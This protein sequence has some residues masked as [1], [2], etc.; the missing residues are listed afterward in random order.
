MT[1]ITLVIPTL[2]ECEALPRLIRCLATLD[3]Q[4]DEIIL[5]DGGSADDTAKL[6]DYAGFKV[7]HQSPKGR[8]RQ[9]NKGVEAA[10]HDVVCVLHADTILPDDAIAVMHETMADEKTVMAAFMAILTGPTKTRWVT[11]FHNWA[12]TWYAPAL[13]RPHLFLRGCRLFFGDHAM[14]FRRQAFLDVGGC[15]PDMMVMEEADLCVKMTGKGRMRLLGRMVATSDRRV[16]AWG[17][18]KAN[19]IYLQVGIKWGF[20]VRKRLG[21]QYPDV[22]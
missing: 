11:S 3:P 12:K 2:D 10:A 9:I 20:G 19:W 7:L 17:G 5:V 8:A 13:F 1:G 15:D 22:R 14:F 6:A 16:A 21:D 18:L 4:P